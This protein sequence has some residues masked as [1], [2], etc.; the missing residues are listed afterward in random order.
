MSETR[1][2]VLVDKAG[3]LGGIGITGATWL[4]SHFSIF[5]AH[6]GALLTP[7]PDPL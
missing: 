1:C 7:V 5:A 2:D 4:H 6:E 3:W